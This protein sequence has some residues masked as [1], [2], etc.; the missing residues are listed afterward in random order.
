MNSFE[1]AI[2]RI[3][4]R[5]NR[6]PITLHSLIDGFPDGSEN[7]VIDAISKLKDS[8]FISMKPGFPLEE[9]FIVYNSEKKKEILKIIDPIQELRIPI[10]N[11]IDKFKKTGGNKEIKKQ[12]PSLKH[13]ILMSIVCIASLG[14][15]T[16]STPIVNDLIHSFDFSSHH[17]QF[18]HGEIYDKIEKFH[19]KL[20]SGEFI[21][22][23]FKS[24]SSI[25]DI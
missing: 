18:N 21:N 24:E 25:Y 4:I 3:L 12:T 19:Q 2:L 11:N 1:I 9:E 15:I 5:R 22:L 7:S 6:Y 16:H 13:S 17:K 20:M 8:D 14:L 10:N 23:N